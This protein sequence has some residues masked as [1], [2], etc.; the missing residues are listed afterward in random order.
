MNNIWYIHIYAI[1]SHKLCDSKHTYLSTAYYTILSLMWRS[2]QGVEVLHSSVLDFP[3]NVV[4]IPLDN[5]LFGTP[6]HKPH[7]HWLQLI[8][9]VSVICMY[10]TQ[11]KCNK[12][13]DLYVCRVVSLIVVANRCIKNVDPNIA[14][15]LHTLNSWSSLKVLAELLGTHFPPKTV[16]NKLVFLL[17]VF[18]HTSYINFII[19]MHDV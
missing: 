15:Q 2:K 7:Q 11:H 13:T 5:L 6:P 12:Y 19:I 8:L 9:H 1:W 10:I 14:R 17:A 4:E 18:I 3:E 16:S